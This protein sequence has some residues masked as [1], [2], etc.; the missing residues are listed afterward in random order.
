MSDLEVGKSSA[1][2]VEDSRSLDEIPT[3]VT[4][5]DTNQARIRRQVGLPL[6]A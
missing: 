2:K 1:L 6:R 4:V 5:S 3:H